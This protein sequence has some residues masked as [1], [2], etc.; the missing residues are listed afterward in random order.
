MCWIRETP[1]QVDGFG[2][3]KIT[4]SEVI[5]PSDLVRLIQLIVRQPDCWHRLFEDEPRLRGTHYRSD[6]PLPVVA[7]STFGDSRRSRMQFGSQQE[8]ARHRH[9]ENVFGSDAFVLRQIRGESILRRASVKDEPLAGVAMLEDECVC[10]NHKCNIGENDE[11]K[12]KPR[13]NL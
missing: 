3:N 2:R 1:T 13:Y 9:Y 6:A 8:H 5:E 4:A 10:E 11:K 12:K 7:L